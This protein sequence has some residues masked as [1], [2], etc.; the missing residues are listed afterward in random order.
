MVLEAIDPFPTLAEELL[1]GPTPVVVEG[2]REGSVGGVRVR[3]P[4]VPPRA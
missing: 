1:D 4:V 2:G 3:W